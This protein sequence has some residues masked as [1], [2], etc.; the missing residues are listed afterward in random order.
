MTKSTVVDRQ[1]VMFDNL[2]NFR[3]I[4]GGVVKVGFPEGEKVG[5]KR[6]KG[7]GHPRVTNMADMATIAAVHEFGSKARNIPARSFLRPAFDVHKKKLMRLKERLAKDMIDG[8]IGFQQAFGILGEFAVNKVKR[9]IDAVMEPPL[10]PES[11]RRK[12]SSKPLIDTGQMR[13]TVTYKTEF[14]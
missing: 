11:I 4:R 5:L 14:K 7:S 2:R 6:S 13:A 8:K 3:R 9:Q 1:S 10:K 12:G